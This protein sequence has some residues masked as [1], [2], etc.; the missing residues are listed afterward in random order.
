MGLGNKYTKNQIDA[1]LS[2]IQLDNH[3]VKSCNEYTYLKI[4]CI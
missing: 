2:N 1:K 4:I 3:E